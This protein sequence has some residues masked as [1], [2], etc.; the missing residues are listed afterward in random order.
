MRLQ[1]AFKRVRSKSLALTV[2]WCVFFAVSAPAQD[3][4]IFAADMIR[5]GDRTPL[6]NL[7]REDPTIWPEGWG[8]MTPLGTNQ[9]YTLGSEMHRLYYSDLLDSNT[10]PQSILVFSTDIDRTKMSARLFMSGL[11]GDAA[12]S[13][14]IHTNVPVDITA[15]FSD[16]NTLSTAQLLF[17]DGGTNFR[18]LLSQYVLQTPEWIATNAAVQPQFARWSNAVNRR[19]ASVQDLGGLS[20]SMFIHQIHHVPL[21]GGLSPQD[22][23]TIIATGRWAFVHEYPPEIGRITGNAFLKKMAEYLEK[24]RREEVSQKKTTLKYVLFS[25]HDSTLLSEMSALKSP[26]TG[27]NAPPYSSYL[28]FGLFEA[29][30][31]NFHLRITYH[32]RADHVVP[33]P[34][35]GSATWPLED[36]SKLAN[37]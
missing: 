6:S 24:A 34:E 10:T 31:T 18:A 14:P 26:L 3:K 25:A 15:G 32:D 8:K 23:E 7:F 37:Q 20:D 2:L 11:L 33:D 12:Q 28:H 4:L 21:P 1:F 17:P 9:E 22:I 5:H 13:L 36:F 19:I 27:T 29:G 30:P 16:G 35:T